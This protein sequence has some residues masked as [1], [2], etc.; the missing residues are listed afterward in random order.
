MIEELR[1]EREIL[2]CFILDPT[3]LEYLDI[4]TP[5]DFLD[6]FCQTVLQAIKELTRENKEITYFTLQEKTEC[7]ITMLIEITD[8]IATTTIIYS[9]IKLLK[10]KSTRRKIVRKASKIIEMTKDNTVDIETLKNNAMQEI[11]NID[12]LINEEIVTLKEAMFETIE[13]LENRQ[14]NKDDKSYYTGVYDYDRVTAG[15]HKEELT[16]I[17]ARPGVGKTAIAMQ[18]GLNIAQNKKNVMFISLEMSVTQLCQRIIAGYAQIDGNKLR[19]GDMDTD[20]WKKTFEVAERFRKENFMIDKTSQNTQHIRAKIRK[21]KPD[22]VIIDYLQL[23]RPVAKHQNREQEIASMTRD[24]KLMTL[25]FKIPIIM[26]SQLN[27]NAEINRPTM[28]DLRESGAIEQDSDN[29][30]FL[31]Q[32]K[33]QEIDELVNDGIY[34]FK[35]IKQVYDKGNKIVDII[36]EKQRNGPVGTFGMVYAPKMMRFYSVNKNLRG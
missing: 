23:L 26:L 22:L 30:V 7:N 6:P 29:I 27:R 11:D 14:S 16:T 12:V 31:H 35:F 15:L 3:T 17:A 4:L 36:L 13:V 2:G 19:T 10:E 18:I 1:L 20:N 9:H 32:L 21:Y 5:D 33:E 34:S 25:E 8:I 24:L 28:R